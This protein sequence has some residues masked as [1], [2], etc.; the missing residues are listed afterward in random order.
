MSLFPDHVS[1]ER[2]Y[3]ALAPPR[4]REWVDA[5]GWR[6][7]EDGRGNRTATHPHAHERIGK[8]AP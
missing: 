4:P 2:R 1:D 6:W 3:S 5:Y 7:R 8:V